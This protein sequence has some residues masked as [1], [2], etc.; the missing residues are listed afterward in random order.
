MAAYQQIVKPMPSNW[1]ESIAFK[2]PNKDDKL[3][4]IDPIQRGTTFRIVSAVE[5]P[6]LVRAVRTPFD[7]FTR[8]D[9]LGKGRGKLTVRVQLNEWLWKSLSNLDKTFSDFLVSNR[10][11]LFSAS[12]ADYIGRDNSA[13][14]LKMKGLA[15]INVDGSP[16][17]EGFITVRINGRC[18]EIDDME[19]K[20]GSSGRYVGAIKWLPRT[21]P[22]PANAT[23]ISLATGSADKSGKLVIR[24]TLP[25]EGSVPVGGQRVRYVGPGDVNPKGSLMCYGLMRPAYWSIAPGGGASISL[26][27]DTMV[28]RNIAEDVEAAPEARYSTPEGFV[29]YEEA[30]ALA[31]AMSAVVADTV[32]AAPQDKKRKLAD[33][34]AT[35]ADFLSPIASSGGYAP[36]APR[37]AA[38]GGAGFSVTSMQRPTPVFTTD[39]AQ[40][41]EEQALYEARIERESHMHKKDSAFPCTQIPEPDEDSL[42]DEE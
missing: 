1:L 2:A 26:V 18:V 3:G 23:R 29:S 34:E 19:I 33:E 14:R 6:L 40:L 17:T 32:Y 8:E 22:L 30:T 35:R 36:G 37:R 9:C 16:Q 11:K 27:M 15:P 10:T 28:V 20:D 39:A 25:V 42:Q 4:Y 24:D 12:D 21:T 41:A 13:I 5:D 38:T 7:C 31:T